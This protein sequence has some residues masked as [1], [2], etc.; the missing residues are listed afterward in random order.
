MQTFHIHTSPFEAPSAQAALRGKQMV[1]GS[2]RPTGNAQAL[3]E[4]C[5]R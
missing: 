3:A 4:R 1:A 5:K 2:A